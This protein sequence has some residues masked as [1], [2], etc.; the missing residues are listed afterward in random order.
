MASQS[1]YLGISVSPKASGFVPYDASFGFS[2]LG[3]LPTGMAL[4]RWPI[5]GECNRHLDFY[6]SLDLQSPRQIAEKYRYA[7]F[8]FCNGYSDY[9]ERGAHQCNPYYPTTGANRIVLLE[10][11]DTTTATRYPGPHPWPECPLEYFEV[12]EWKDMKAED[13]KAFTDAILN[14]VFNENGMAQVPAPQLGKC[15]DTVHLLNCP[16]WIQNDETPQCPTCNGPVKFIGQFE[17]PASP[18]GVAYAFLC[19]NECSPDGSYLMFQVD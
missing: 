13:S 1:E 16:Q 11:T 8:F 3:G 15:L 6:F 4:D 2:K 18:T 10:E 14:P 7:Y 9:Y 5:C 12:A 17:P 19:D